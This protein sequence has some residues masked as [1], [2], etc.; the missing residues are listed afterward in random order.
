MKAT[1]KRIL[2]LTAILALLL[3]AF[4]LFT[5]L[6]E[7]AQVAAA[8]T[9]A[10]QTEQNNIIGKTVV[11]YQAWFGKGWY[12]PWGSFEIWPSVGDYPA[13]SLWDSKFNDLGNGQKAQL[14]DS[15]DAGVIETHFAWMEKYGIDCAAVQRFYAYV[16]SGG[17]KDHVKF[18]YLKTIMQ[19]AQAHNR[20]FY[21]MYDMSGAKTGSQIVENVKNDFI[22]N[23][24]GLGLVSSKAYAHAE[25][26][27]VVCLW[28]LANSSNYPEY[29]VAYPLVKWFKDR[30]YYVICGTPDNNFHSDTTDYAKVY[31]ESDMISP[32]YVGRFGPNSLGTLTSLVRKDK[33]WCDD[34]GKEYLPVI[35]PGFGWANMMHNGKY[36][37]HPR[38]AGDFLWKEAIRLAITGCKGAYFAMFDEYDEGTAIMKAAS[39]S[40]MIPAGENDYYTT[41]SADGSWISDD[42]YLRLAGYI[43]QFLKDVNA[44]K[45]DPTDTDTYLDLIAAVPIRHSEGPVY[46]R[47]NF[48]YKYVNLRVGGTD[49]EPQYERTAMRIDPC[50]G[51]KLYSVERKGSELVTLT[52]F[53]EAAQQ[54]DGNWVY[55]FAGTSRG[56]EGNKATVH[57]LLNVANFELA[58]DT[59]ISYTLKAND[60]GGEKVYVNLL[61]EGDLLLSQ[62]M[63]QIRNTGAKSGQTVTVTLPVSNDLA[64]KVVTGILVSYES[65]TAESFSAVLDNMLIEIGEEGAGDFAA[66]KAPADAL[67]GDADGDGKITSTD[68]RLTLQ[69]SVDKIKASD[70]ANPEAV[71]V[72]RDGKITSTDA[73]LILQYSVN[74]IT[75][76]P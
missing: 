1:V 23:I 37:E 13:A 68:A 39:D 16:L 51:D 36:N 73:R 65:E 62:E 70:V 24:E 9:F 18:S 49:D 59:V 72:D 35:F 69:L 31:A 66:E 42:F 5:P 19:Q 44:G 48:T 7:T 22:N 20:S 76:W 67:T 21:I 14:F 40:T 53:D 63:T 54:R 8:P 41:M 52:Q 29:A 75:E 10:R 26:K 33:G 17:A 57:R 34:N 71:D 6:G 61:L 30:G 45:L 50:V 47:N 2:S 12:H 64:G 55:T 46:Y 32:W 25:G 43:G 58:R 4:G 74:K 38:K 56:S 60:A 11:G 27:P 15:R 3:A 28:G